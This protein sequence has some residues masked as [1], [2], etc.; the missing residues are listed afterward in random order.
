M[1]GDSTEMVWGVM[2]T[3]PRTDFPDIRRKTSIRS[4][5]GTIMIIPREGG[6]LVR[7]YIEL[8]PNTRA[9]DVQLAELQALAKKIFSPYIMDYAQTIWWSAYAVT[10]RHADHFHKSHRVFLAGDAAHCHSAKAGQ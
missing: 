7:L 2:D 10:Q 3:V 8:P 9:K 6:S 5:F 4:N 1:V